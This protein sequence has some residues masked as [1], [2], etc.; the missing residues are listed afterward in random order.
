MSY[1]RK[2]IP[3]I[4]GRYQYELEGMNAYAEKVARELVDMYPNID[5]MDIQSRFISNFNFEMSREI[6]R[7]SIEED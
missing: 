4:N 6:A 7:A 1:N 3:R 2:P 5:V